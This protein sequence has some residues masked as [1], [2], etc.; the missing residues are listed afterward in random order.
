MCRYQDILHSMHL[1][2]KQ[3][4]G[5]KIC[6]GQQELLN[7][8]RSDIVE[9]ATR[10]QKGGLGYLDDATEFEARV[11]RCNSTVCVL[12]YGTRLSLFVADVH[13]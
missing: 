5:L 4:L 6:D 12:R 7:F 11:S 13:F 8:L 1:A 3:N 9:V 2:R 10:L